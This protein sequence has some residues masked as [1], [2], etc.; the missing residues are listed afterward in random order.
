MLSC[1]IPAA[2]DRDPHKGFYSWGRERD[3]GAGRRHGREDG[4]A[5]GRTEPP[6]FSA[7]LSA[8]LAGPGPWFADQRRSERSLLCVL[9][10]LVT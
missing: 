9:L 8:R 4:D 1:L 10:D 6:G 3:S 5:G 2:L 7:G